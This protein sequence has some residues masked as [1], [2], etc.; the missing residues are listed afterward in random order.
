MILGRSWRMLLAVACAVAFSVPAPARSSALLVHVA[1]GNGTLASG[2]SL[3]ISAAHVAGVGGTGSATYTLGTS[4]VRIALTC[5]EVIVTGAPPGHSFYASGIGS[6]LLA[7]HIGINDLPTGPD[8]AAVA[9]PALITALPCGAPAP[10][11]LP[12]GA[13]AFAIFV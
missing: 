10:V 6:D 11:P 3:T 13:N 7:Y 5:V 9:P 8:E 1:T 2:Y 4:V 12:G